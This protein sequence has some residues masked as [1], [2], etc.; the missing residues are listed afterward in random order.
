VGGFN[1]RIILLIGLCILC[2]AAVSASVSI[3]QS[4]V[5]TTIYI[6]EEAQVDLTITNNGQFSERFQVFSNDPRFRATIPGGDIRIE[7][8]ETKQ[9]RAT[10]VPVAMM[11]PGTYGV[12]IG[13]KGIFYGAQAEI[14]SN[15]GIRSEVY[16]EFAPS[17]HTNVKINDGDPVDPRNPHTL[18]FRL[19]NQNR[20][21]I[22]N[23]TI[24]YASSFCSGSF[25]SAL[26]PQG[27]LQ[28]VETCD[29]ARHTAP[30]T[31]VLRVTLLINGE[32][33]RGMETFEYDIGEV[34][35]FFNVEKDAD[36][37]F[38]RSTLNMSITND[39]NVQRQQ[40]FTVQRNRFEKAFSTLSST[41]NVQM[42]EVNQGYEFT[43]RLAPGEQAVFSV[44]TNLRGFFITL[45]ILAALTAL[46]IFLYFALRSP[47]LITRKVV[48]DIGK[49]GTADKTKVILNVRNRSS[50]LLERVRVIETVPS[51]VEVEKAFDVGTLKPTKIVKHEKKG[52]LIRWDFTSLEPYEERIITYRLASKLSI[53]GKVQLP[54]TIVKFLAD[55]GHS[56]RTVKFTQTS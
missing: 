45:A 52:T 24:Q 33:I 28:K 17:I 8:K 2:T 46:G 39:A 1:L 19:V 6:D 30:Q 41:G 38:L 27:E 25:T 51:I 36:S 13:T 22:T 54:A 7:P 9:V 18:A 21:D 35:A 42:Q 20:L 53:V 12:S 56:Q 31:D 26:P 16:R 5:L 50:K 37:F 3:S 43:V 4:P 44:D 29:I 49:D 55:N 15:I 48:H 14:I 40:V 23:L 10:V 47:I 34:T 32:P 11:T